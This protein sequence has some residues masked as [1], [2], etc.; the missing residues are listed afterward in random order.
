MAAAVGFVIAATL[1]I[2]A[3]LWAAGPRY[4]VRRDPTF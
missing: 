1:A 2:D 3:A 4:E